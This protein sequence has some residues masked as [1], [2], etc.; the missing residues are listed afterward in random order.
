MNQSLSAALRGSRAAPGAFDRFLRRRLLSQLDGLAAAYLPRAAEVSRQA[1][2]LAA[3]VDLEYA[4]T[5]GE[6]PP[7]LAKIV[8]GSEAMR[9]AAILH[10]EVQLLRFE[11]GN[12]LKPDSAA[13]SGPAAR[14]IA[15]EMARAGGRA[16][17]R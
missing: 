13:R 5:E 12:M 1:W 16:R 14:L 3:M 6:R 9:R 17:A 8:A 4:Q 15:R 11:I 2:S 7:N 10:P